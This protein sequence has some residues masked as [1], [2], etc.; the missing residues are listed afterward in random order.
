MPPL[1]A[2]RGVADGPATVGA[3]ATGAG[4][5]AEPAGAGVAAPTEAVEPAGAAEAEAAAAV[6]GFFA[7]LAWASTDGGPNDAPTP[8]GAITTS[9]GTTTAAQTALCQ[10]ILDPFFSRF[11]PPTRRRSPPR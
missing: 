2:G 5:A 1:E 7:P 6:A 11:F 3:A 9:M 4:A 10:R 8:S